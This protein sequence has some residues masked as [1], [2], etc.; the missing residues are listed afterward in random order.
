MGNK[1]LFECFLDADSDYDGLVTYKGFNKMIAQAASI[2]RRFGFA[3]HTREMYKTEAEFTEARKALFS[4]LCGA[5]GGVSLDN[6][7]G[8]AKPHIVQ[9]EVSKAGSAHNKKTTE[10]TQMKELYILT[11][12]QFI[13]HDK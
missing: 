1:F 10:S 3:P 8:W 11:S 7:I 2:P 6:W 9:K 13:H 4:Q 12:R 5:G